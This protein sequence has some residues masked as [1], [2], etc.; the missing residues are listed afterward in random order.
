[1]TRSE[2]MRRLWEDAEFRRRAAARMSAMVRR[3]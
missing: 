2:N 1:M 3:M